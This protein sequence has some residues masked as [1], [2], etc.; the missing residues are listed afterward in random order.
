MVGKVLADESTIRQTIAGKM[1]LGEMAVGKSAWFQAISYQ[2]YVYFKEHI[3]KVFLAGYALNFHPGSLGTPTWAYNKL[4]AKTSDGSG[5]K[6]FDPGPDNFLWLG[7]GWVSHSW[8]GFE[9]GK[10]P[11]KMSNF[12][13]L[14]PSDQKNLFGSGQKVPGSKAVNLLF[15]AGQ[16]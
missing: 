10:F 11:L 4:I 12:S 6:I 3:V 15:S 13:I 16:K 8:F 1:P 14:F 7:S 9:F 5:S 2:Y